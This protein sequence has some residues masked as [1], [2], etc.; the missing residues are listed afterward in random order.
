MKKATGIGCQ[1]K[2]NGSDSKTETFQIQRSFKWRNRSTSVTQVS[3][4]VTLNAHFRPLYARLQTAHG[5]E[6]SDE[7]DAAV[8]AGGGIG[9]QMEWSELSANN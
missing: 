7:D 9:D 2:C 8:P 6:I 5:N 3:F 4:Y 1:S